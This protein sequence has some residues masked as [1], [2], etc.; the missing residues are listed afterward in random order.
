M[1][2]SET[3]AYMNT[4]QAINAIQNFDAQ[5]DVTFTAGNESDAVYADIGA[6]PVDSVEKIY[7]KVRVK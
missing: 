7:M 2:K 6:Q 1:L 3:V 4:L 5:T